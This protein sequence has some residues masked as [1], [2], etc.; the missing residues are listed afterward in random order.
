MADSSRPFYRTVRQFKE[1]A[2]TDSGNGRYVRH[3]AY[4]HDDASSYIR[5]FLLLQD[6]L[7][8]LFKYV[9]PGD[10]NLP[11][12][13]FRIHELLVRTCIEVEAN[14]KAILTANSYT[15]VDKDGKP[16]DLNM[17]D[18]KKIERSHFLSQYLV[19]VPYWSG[20]KKNAIRHPF[21][22][23]STPNSGL[24]WYKAYNEVKHDRSTHLP[25]ASFEN[26][27]D[28]FCGL[29]VVLTAQFLFEDFSNGHDY[30]VANN[31]ADEFEPAVGDFFL[32][33]LPSMMPERY[34]FKWEELMDEEDPFVTFD[35]SSTG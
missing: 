7:K 32:V 8:D 10:V 33:S 2:Y 6:D 21:A 35:Y 31:M 18:Y 29:I 34:D 30:L 13:S 3:G 14:L 27:M 17:T 28:A 16:A 9:E 20:L 23:W 12:F 5:G 1:G 4:S 26:L 22:A 19:K 25:L 24:D 15:K 11:V